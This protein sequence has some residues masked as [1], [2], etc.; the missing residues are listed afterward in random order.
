MGWKS[1][2]GGLSSIQ[3]VTT[4]EN[5][6]GGL[7]VRKIG[8]AAAAAVHL[9]KLLPLLFHPD[10]AEWMAGDFNPLY[11][12]G[13]VGNIAIAAFYATYMEDLKAANAEGL[14]R[15]I[16]GVL[17]LESLI[18]VFHLLTTKRST[19]KRAAIA[20]PAGK[21]PTSVTSRIVS[22]TVTVVSS[23]ASLI[24]LRDLFF[25]GF[26]FEFIPRDDIYLEWTNAFLHSPPEGS[27]EA[28]DHG[29]E[30]A[31]F[32]GDKF[33]SH[34]MALHM[35]ILIGYKFLTAFGIKYGSDGS[36]LFKCKMIWK[37]QCLGNLFVLLLLRLFSQAA[38]SASLDLRWHLMLVGYET[39]ILGIFFVF[40][41]VSVC[42]PCS[43]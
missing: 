4:D 14:P 38:L 39:F 31:L 42:F 23:V 35:L 25:P 5:N 33:V 28:D 30:A 37:A 40:R 8:G 21:T 34:F 36:G 41:N 6:M 32:S 7:F 20:M 19:S 27:P 17:A 11:W 12:M 2:Q 1:I 18:I 13:V 9:Q 29:L 15:F 10:G 43:S 22:R 16:M 3:A 24:L 26:I